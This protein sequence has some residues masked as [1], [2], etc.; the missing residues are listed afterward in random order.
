MPG[1]EKPVD[2]TM[3][4]RLLQYTGAH[5]A[6]GARHKAG[7]GEILRATGYVFQCIP[8][9]SHPTTERSQCIGKPRRPI[10]STW[11][12]AG[13]VVS[14]LVGACG[15]IV[16]GLALRAKTRD[17][18]QGDAEWRGSVNA[19]LERIRSDLDEVRQIVFARF[20]GR[21]LA[22]RSP[23]RLTKLGKTVSVEIGASPRAPDED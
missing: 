10:P 17:T 1:R 14:L 3:P 11:T 12:A 22:S 5:P 8:P 13:V 9:T 6:R 7:R 23:L 4:L 2:H 18:A 20:G 15:V 21:L 19:L 16:A